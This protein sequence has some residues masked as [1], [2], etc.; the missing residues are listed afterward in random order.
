ME[1]QTARNFVLP[2]GKHEGKRI[3]T[4]A[5]RNDG[6]LYLDW[7]RSRR[8]EERQRT[9]TAS[10]DANLDEALATYLDDGTV[11]RDLRNLLRRMGGRK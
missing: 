5:E 8:D 9:G 10:K 4:V 7:L 6:L 2:F 1:F 3:G 11:A